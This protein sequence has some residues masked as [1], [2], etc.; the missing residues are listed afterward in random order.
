M[1]NAAPAAPVAPAKQSFLKGLAALFTKKEVAGREPR[2]L[3]VKNA[4]ADMSDNELRS[5]LDREL[6]AIV[7]GYMWIEAV[8][9]DDGIVVFSSMPRE[10]WLY[11]Q[12]EFSV[13]GGTVKLKGE[14]VEVE[15]VTRF[16]PADGSGEGVKAASA[17]CGCGGSKGDEMSKTIKER[18]A[19]L[20]ASPKNAFTA[21]QAPVFETFT[22]AQLKA[23]EDADA[24]AAGSTPPAQPETPPAT[25]PASSTPSAQAPGQ[26]GPTATPAT[27]PA[28]SPAE[29]GERREA[30]SREDWIKAAPPEV[31]TLL[32]REE[33]RE[34]ATKDALVAKLKGA[35][36]A[37][38]ET[39]LKALSI[40]QLNKLAQI[41][42]VKTGPV[43]LSLN[44][45]RDAASGDDE[46][47]P[48]A[49]S[50]LKA[51]R[52]QKKPA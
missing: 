22:D 25:P 42:N 6:R 2:L 1:A 45:P 14:P 46:V 16:E 29:S 48:P 5:N 38:T 12:Q 26:T 36:S 20:I 33:A 28:S 3:S 11:F 31:R 15:P 49:P 4:A 35:Q 32:E 39:E 10:N 9:P 43:D 37:Y 13:R 52:E 30:M 21:A 18:V 19:A 41:A 17:P 40:D 7:P 24:A 23:L 8:F 44:V 34:K 27:P 47:I 50:I 51:L